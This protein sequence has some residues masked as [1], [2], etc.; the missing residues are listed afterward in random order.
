MIRADLRTR[1][2]EQNAM[3]ASPTDVGMVTHP[4]AAVNLTIVGAQGSFRRHL[5]ATNKAP[6][7]GDH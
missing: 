6:R 2:R 7:T 1:I 4:L 3:T 5:P